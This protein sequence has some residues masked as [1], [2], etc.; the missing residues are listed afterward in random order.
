MSCY[1]ER[2]EPSRSALRFFAGAGGQAD[3]RMQQPP[4]KDDLAARFAPLSERERQVV[5][6]VCEGLSNKLIGRELNVSD[7]TIKCHL[8]AI[9]TKLGV[10]SRY[11][12]LAVFDRHKVD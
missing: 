12:L 3:G 7:G 1:A 8:H 11:E 9:Y 2:Q 5:G 4:N 6:L 10:Q